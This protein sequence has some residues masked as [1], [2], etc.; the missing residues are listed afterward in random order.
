MDRKDQYQVDM[1]IHTTASDGTWTM[2]KLLE[3]ILKSN[4]K[5]FSITDHDTIENSIK[6]FHRV[7]DNINYVIGTEISCTYDMEEYHIT[8][9]DFDYRNSKLNGLIEFN[10]IRRKEFNRKIIEFVKEIDKITDIT[11]YFLYKYDRNRGGWES[12]NYLLDK[13][14]VGN[15]KEYFEIVKLSNKKIRFK[16][17]QE[18]IDIIKDAGGHPFLAHPSAYKNGGKLPA[19]VLKE[20]KAYGISGIE[21]FSPY[22][23]NIEDGNYYVK[24]CNENNL[25]ISA[26]SDCHGEFNNRALGIPKVGVDEIRL[27]FMKNI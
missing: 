23:R 22:L 9:Y 5:L 4:I 24:F 15:L 25:M 16:S 18:V 17:P 13:N 1:H 8:A 2:E 11:D 26:G 21:C 12:L 10:Q 14:I 3:F 19:E 7:P 6:M 20:W 27:D